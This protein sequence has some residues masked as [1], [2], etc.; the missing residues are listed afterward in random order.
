VAHRVKLSGG[1]AIYFW[2]ISFKAEYVSHLITIENLV[3]AETKDRW[4]W[5]TLA[6][7]APYIE[8]SELK[9]M[10]SSAVREVGKQEKDHAAWSQKVL[11]KLAKETPMR[12]QIDG[13]ERS[14]EA[15]EDAVQEKS[16]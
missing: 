8:D 4:E 12:Q 3:L 7:L 1:H 9:R 5:Q 11:T 13:M 16:R 2:L 15:D 6:T 10:A 14:E